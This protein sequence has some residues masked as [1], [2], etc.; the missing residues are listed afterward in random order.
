MTDNPSIRKYLYKIEKK[1]ISEIKT[2][3]CLEQLTPETIK[4]LES[5]NNKQ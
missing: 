2:G 5:I 3:Y 1:I 4:L